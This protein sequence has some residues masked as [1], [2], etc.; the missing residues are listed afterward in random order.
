MADNETKIELPKVPKKKLRSLVLI[1]FLAIAAASAVIFILQKE[2]HNNKAIKVSGN[3]EGNDVRIS[4]RVEGQIEELL[5]D[6]G[7]VI[8][9]EES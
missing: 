6:E 9:T 5:A 3:I 7:V 1:V 8:K 4:F 2:F